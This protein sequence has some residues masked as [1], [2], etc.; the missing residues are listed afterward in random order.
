MFNLFLKKSRMSEKTIWMSV[1][2]F[3]IRKAFF[4][5]LKSLKFIKTLF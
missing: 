4:L 1:E 2:N 5:I 3:S